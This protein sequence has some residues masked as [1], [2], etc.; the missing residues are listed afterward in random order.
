[1]SAAT[2]VAFP[3]GATAVVDTEGGVYTVPPDGTGRGTVVAKPLADPAAKARVVRSPDGSAAWVL[4][5]EVQ[6]DGR[7]LRVRK[8]DAGAVRSDTTAPL[9]DL[10]AGPPLASEG[11]ILLPLADGFVHRLGDDGTLKRGPA[12]RSPGAKP[13]AVCF[14][15]A[16]AGPDFAATDGATRVTRWRWPAGGTPAKVAGPWE[17]RTPIRLPPAAFRDRDAWRIAVA[18]AGG[19]A[20]FE[21]DKTDDALTRW[22]SAKDNT[23]P[24]GPPGVAVTPVE[25]G[26]RDLIVYAVGGR[27][28]VALD[29]DQTNPAWLTWV[30]PDDGP[31]LVGWVAR[32]PRIVATDQGGRVTVVSSEKGAVLAASPAPAPGAFATIPAELAGDRA[33]VGLAD[34]TAQVVPLK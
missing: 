27:R 5:P 28:L 33:V 19:L 18:D 15:C 14:L 20:L 10:P 21:A 24:A 2:P 26:P 32:G 29:A 30:C 22:R 9:A 31:E 13:D 6:K 7:K 12:W 16:F 17:S 4:V 23:V 11:G 1:V 3:G 34:G 25:F 8:L